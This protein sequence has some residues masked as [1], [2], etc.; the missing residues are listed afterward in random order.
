MLFLH[1]SRSVANT[2]ANASTAETSVAMSSRASVAPLSFPAHVP[3]VFSPQPDA[4]EWKRRFEELTQREA[5]LAAREAAVAAREDTLVGFLALYELTTSY[6]DDMASK[7]LSGE[8]A[9]ALFADFTGTNNR[10]N[11]AVNQTE[12]ALSPPSTP[13]K[14]T[15]PVEELDRTPSDPALTVDLPSCPPSPIITVSPSKLL[16]APVTPF[17]SRHRPAKHED[18]SEPISGALTATDIRGPRE[19]YD[20]NPEPGFSARKAL[21]FAPDET[22]VVVV[23]CSSDDDL[24]PPPT[25]MEAPSNSK[26]SG[27]ILGKD[28]R[29]R[30][31][32]RRA[33]TGPRTTPNTSLNTSMFSGALTGVNKSKQSDRSIDSHVPQRAFSSKSLQERIHEESAQADWVTNHLISLMTLQQEL[34]N[35]PT[36]Q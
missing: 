36:R 3:R 33:T 20:T 1:Q 24:G 14:P 8:T 23:D 4:S 35:T 15:S 12:V 2:T 34:H 17:P 32:F 22:E 30:R 11:Q 19:S 27:P 21:N 6:L 13:S 26:R 31:I 29:I 28:R 18:D 16:S 9:T 5:A 25:H 10:P 7:G